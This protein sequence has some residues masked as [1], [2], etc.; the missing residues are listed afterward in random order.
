MPE[1]EWSEKVA[2]AGCGKQV[3]LQLDS[4]VHEREWTRVTELYEGGVIDDGAVELMSRSGGIDERQRNR[5][6]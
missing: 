4:V 6:T 1:L 2:W 5:H 3:H